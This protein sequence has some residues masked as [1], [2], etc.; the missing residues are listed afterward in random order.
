MSG[1]ESR[2]EYL[3]AIFKL[4]AT[5]PGATVTT[6]AQQLGVT[7]ASASEMVGRLTKAGSLLRD[8]RS[9][10]LLRYWSGGFVI[11]SDAK[12]PGRCS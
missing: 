6:V 3:E 1:T 10:I 4:A 12:S 11:R 9:R 7:R 5:S 8:G 2:E